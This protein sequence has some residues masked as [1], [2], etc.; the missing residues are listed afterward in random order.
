MRCI[1]PSL[2]Y[3]MLTLLEHLMRALVWG[4]YVYSFDAC[5]GQVWYTKSLSFM[6]MYDHVWDFIR[7]S[8]CIVGL[9]RVPATLSRSES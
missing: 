6:K 8:G 2:M 4:F 7:Y 5:T 9:L 1:E 3:E